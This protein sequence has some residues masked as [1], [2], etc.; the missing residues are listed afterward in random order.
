[1]GLSQPP[2]ADKPDVIRR[3][4]TQGIETPT[5]LCDV[6]QSPGRSL[7]TDRHGRMACPAC[8]VG[9]RLIQEIED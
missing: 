3:G 7:E 8:F 1:M 5:R 4:V 6:C 2:S 9:L